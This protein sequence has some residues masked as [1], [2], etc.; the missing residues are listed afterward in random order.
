MGLLFIPKTIYKY[1]TVVEWYWQGKTEELG[2]EPVTVPFC[3]PQIPHE[4]TQ[5]QTQAS[6]VRGWWLSTLAMEWPPSQI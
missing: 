4:M 2:E 6:T 3:A 1:A 5:A